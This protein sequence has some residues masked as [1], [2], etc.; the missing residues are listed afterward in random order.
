MHEFECVGV[1][2]STNSCGW[3]L[4]LSL[5]VTVSIPVFWLTL[6]KEKNIASVPFIASNWMP[7]TKISL[8][9]LW[10][11]VVGGVSFVDVVCICF[12][13]SG[14]AIAASAP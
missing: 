7:N 3:H 5:S 12:R 14:G 11:K 9:K 8:V 6:C 4:S 13:E 2:E 10:H 1:E